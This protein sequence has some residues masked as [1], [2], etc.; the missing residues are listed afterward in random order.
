MKKILAFILVSAMIFTIC[1]CGSSQEQVPETAKDNSVQSTE[2]TDE[3]MEAAGEDSEPVT[4]TLFNSKSEISEALVE[5]AAEYEKEHP[6]VTLNVETVAATDYATPLK[7]RFTAGEA[8]DIFCNTGD[9]ELDAWI[10]Y[11]EDLSDQPW[12]DDMVEVTKDAISRDGK[13]YG[14]AM[15]I[16]AVGMVYNKDLF[17]QAGIEEAPVTFSELVEVVDKL[18]AAGITPFTSSY[19]NFVVGGRFALNNPVSKQPGGAR[20]FID[21]LNNGT[22][23]FIDN[24]VFD[25]FFDLLDLE[26]NH[27]VSDPI[28]T[29]YNTQMAQFANGEAAMCLRG[30]FIE[31]ILEGLNPDMNLGLFGLPLSDDRTLNDMI[32]VGTSTYW[33]INKDSQV[34]EEAK[35]FLNWL[36]TSETGK[37]Y[38]TDHFHFVSS[39]TTIQANPETI[40]DISQGVQQYVNEEKNF[41]YNWPKYP[42]GSVNELGS[43]IQQ[44][45]AGEIDRETTL[46]NLQQAWDN[47]K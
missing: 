41:S 37:Q 20:A 38:I 34:K 3:D 6:G 47:Y 4:I 43:V 16:E 25:G 22:A 2:N 36:V 40:G 5:L 7:A 17:E 32:F 23:S 9:S 14:M 28:T 15:N 44:Y 45:V 19:A 31:P 13:I 26:I 30:N 10:E 33:V 12:V 8:P 21:G 29:D 35:E 42:I 18:E 27:C 11:L 39:I 1:A 24:E 46:V